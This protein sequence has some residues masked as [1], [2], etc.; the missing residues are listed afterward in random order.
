M[1]LS[2]ARLVALA[3]GLALTTLLVLAAALALGSAGFDVEMVGW[4]VEQQ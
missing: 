2:A 3:L 4:L 1:P